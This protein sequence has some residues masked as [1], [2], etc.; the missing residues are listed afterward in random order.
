MD[1]EKSS[2]KSLGGV[3]EAQETNI[4]VAV[5]LEFDFLDRTPQQP[6]LQFSCEG[7]R[8]T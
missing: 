8:K 7:S 3:Y 1:T 5:S 4:Q 2:E 6:F